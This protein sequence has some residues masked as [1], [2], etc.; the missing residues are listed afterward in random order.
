MRFMEEYPRVDL[1][2]YVTSRQVDLLAENFDVAIRA[3]R[4]SCRTPRLS[5]AHS[6]SPRGFSLRAASIS[7]ALDLRRRLKT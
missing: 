6:P 4:V 2:E 3:T 5:A 7:S 1:V